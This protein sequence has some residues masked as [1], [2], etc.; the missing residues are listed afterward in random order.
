MGTLSWDY[1]IL[2]SS[3]A[4]AGVPAGE[5]FR[6]IFGRRFARFA[7][8]DASSVLAEIWLILHGCTLSCL[9]VRKPTLASGT[10]CRSVRCWRIPEGCLK[11]T[12]RLDVGATLDT[13]N[14]VCYTLGSTD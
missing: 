10:R 3:P 4:A 9:L 13:A 5:A 8:L 14:T 7:A 2:V 1:T 12:T 11:P 6:R